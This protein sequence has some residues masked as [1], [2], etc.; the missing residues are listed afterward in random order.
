VTG[1]TVVLSSHFDDAVLSLGGWLYRAARSGE[2]VNVLTV[3]GGDPLSTLPAGTWDSAAGFRTAGA[4]L[5]ARREEDRRA[6]A[7]I[8]VEG[9]SLP[10]FDEQYG[11]RVSDD[12]IAAAIAD[13]TRGPQVLL[14]PGFPLTHPDHE[15]V[16]RAVLS[17]PRGNERLGLYVE[18][19]YALTTTRRLGDDEPV[20]HGAWQR[21]GTGVIP[22]IA[23]TRACRAYRSQVPLLGVPLL[24]LVLAEERIAWI[25]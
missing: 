23:K 25:D 4:A 15:Q 6:C 2:H 10:F 7:A 8:G 24:R 5:Q 13:A 3:F 16:A 9:S 18:H 19:P 21:V 14:V 17:L 12:E 11:P 20:P 1:R 22:K